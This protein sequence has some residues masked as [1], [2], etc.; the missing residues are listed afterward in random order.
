MKLKT[1]NGLNTE[2]YDHLEW[3]EYDSEQQVIDFYSIL[4]NA[5]DDFLEV[6]KPC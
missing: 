2:T 6:L 4:N 1:Y 5:T 3:L